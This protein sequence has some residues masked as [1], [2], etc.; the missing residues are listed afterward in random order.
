[1]AP[2]PFLGE[3]QSLFLWLLHLFETDK[4]HLMKIIQADPGSEK[5]GNRLPNGFGEA[6]QF[7]FDFGLGFC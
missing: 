6:D 4:L 7:L 3:G 1:M 5:G 2:N